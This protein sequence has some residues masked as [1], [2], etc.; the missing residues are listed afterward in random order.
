MPKSVKLQP[1][2]SSKYLPGSNITDGH[3]NSLLNFPINGVAGYTLGDVVSN[4][5]LKPEFT[6]AFEIG[7]DLAFFNDRVGITADYYDNVSDGQI[8]TAPFPAS[9]GFLGKVINAGIFTNKGIEALLRLTPVDSK[10]DCVGIF[11]LLIPKIPAL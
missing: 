6:K 9:S 10:K 1:L 3:A 11:H 2:R 7:V 4:P 5:D 8:F